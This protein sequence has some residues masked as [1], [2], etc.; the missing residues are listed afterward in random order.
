MKKLIILICLLALIISPVHADDSVDYSGKIFMEGELV[1]NSLIKI[2]VRAEE[3]Q[4]ESLGIAFNLIYEKDKLQ[5][6]RYLPGDFLEL[7]GDPFYLVKNSDGKVIFGETLSRSDYFPSGSGE[8]AQFYFQ[9]KEGDNFS[10]SFDKG[11]L[12]TFDEVRQD[13]LNIFWE[14]YQMSKNDGLIFSTKSSVIGIEEKSGVIT[15][16]RVGIFILSSILGVF[17]VLIMKKQQRKIGNSS[18]NFN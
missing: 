10:F 7:G 1:D 2:S 18:V 16:F 14:P 9:I 5:F 3:V 4:D 13:L 11:V 12:S 8:V 6:V 15:F 17:V